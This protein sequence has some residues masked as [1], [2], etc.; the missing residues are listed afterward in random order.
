M[1]FDYDKIPAGYYDTV[2][3]RGKGAQS[4]WHHLHFA[5]VATEIAG[6]RRHLDLGCGPGTFMGAFAEDGRVAVGVDISAVQI[7]YARRVYESDTRTFLNGAAEVGTLDKFDAVTALQVIEHLSPGDVDDLLRDG[8]DHLAPGGKLVVTTPNFNSA[9]PVVEAL[10]NR[11]GEVAYTSQHINRFT[12]VRLAKLLE[13]LGLVDVRVET[14]MLVATFAASLSWRLADHLTS[15]ERL[16][17]LRRV[18]LVLLG[19]GIKPAT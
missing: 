18:G 2:F 8:V 11:Y 9:W 5:R 3:R 14:Y 16:P 10:V 12:R 13:G 15:I 17:G 19:T 7:A 4:K 1:G 6:R